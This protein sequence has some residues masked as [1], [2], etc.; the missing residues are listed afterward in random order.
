MES[1]LPREPTRPSPAAAA[2][3]ALLAKRRRAEAELNRRRRARRESAQDR[4]SKAVLPVLLRLAGLWRRGRANSRAL[5][6]TRLDWA[7]P[8]LPPAFDGFRILHLTDT[9]FGADEPM[10]A[11]VAR[12]LDAVEADVCVLTGD[13]A[14]HRAGPWDV[15]GAELAAL[16]GA[17]HVPRILATLGNHDQ[18]PLIEHLEAAGAEVLMHTHRVLERDGGRLVIAGVDDAHDYDCADPALALDG[19]PD[20]AFAVMLAHTPESADAV[21]AAGARLC[22][23]GHTH[24]GQVCLPGGIPIITNPRAPRARCRGE[25]RVDGLRGYTSRGLGTTAV[26]VRYNCPP[27]AVLLT[28]RRGSDR[29]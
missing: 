11:R 14:F 1:S 27:E 16:C 23:C 15:V 19:A 26:R 3:E 13:Y 5:E 21:A 9:H 6:V 2:R 24:G 18:S 7:W 12:Q 8:E 17:L 10:A 25:W 22:L 29:R 20:D 28:L 4:G